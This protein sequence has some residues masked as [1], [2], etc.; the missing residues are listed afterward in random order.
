MKGK[1]KGKR[2]SFKHVS[3]KDKHNTPGVTGYISRTQVTKRLQLNI[4]QFRQLCILKGVHPVEPGLKRIRRQNSKTWYYMKD[5]NFLRRDEIMDWF[6][7][8]HIYKRKM[9]HLKGVKK[10][11]EL[12][13]LKQNKPRLNMDHFVRERYPSLQDAV[14]DLDDAASLIS[15]F[16]EMQYG[17]TARLMKRKLFQEC[18]RLKSEWMAYVTATQALRKV[19]V[20]IKGIYYQAEVMG[21]VVTW[22]VPHSQ[23]IRVPMS[24][25]VVTMSFFVQFYVTMMNFVLYRLYTDQGYKYPP[26]IEN[27]ILSEGLP[28][29]AVQIEKETAPTA[30]LKNETPAQPTTAPVPLTTAEKERIAIINSKLAHIIELDEKQT[31]EEESLVAD[32]K[33]EPMDAAEKLKREEEEGEV[34][35]KEFQKVDEAAGENK[36]QYQR[37]ARLFAGM[38]FFINREIPSKGEISFMIRAFGGEEFTDL[39]FGEKDNRITHQVVDREMHGTLKTN[40]EYVQPQWIFDSINA[41][42][43]LPYHEYAHNATLPPHISP[44][45]NDTLKG[46]TPKQRDH[47]NELIENEKGGKKEKKKKSEEEEDEESSKYIGEA[48]EDDMTEL[49]SQY[50]REMDAERD[51]RSYAGY[52]E[53]ETGKTEMYEDS[54]ESGSDSEVDE[55]VKRKPKTRKEL[56]E[57]RMK[58][59][60][61]EMEEM[62]I[63]LLNRKKRRLVKSIKGRLERNKVLNDALME[64]RVAIEKKE[65]TAAKKAK[66]A[67]PPTSEGPTNKRKEEVVKAVTDKPAKKAKK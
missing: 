38:K 15:L 56:I 57:E 65:K 6:R 11:F 24:I 52:V 1:K 37:K 26:K 28:V 17:I 59:E 34:V 47:I 8:T 48:D 4:Q 33:D 31:I 40:R 14:N 42:I 39:D 29:K 45:V 67:L 18:V 53:D 9:A 60:E 5:I 51:G 25:D 35:P 46:Y 12:A 27:D 32:V 13:A 62:S 10:P 44:F 54:A 36:E 21:S 22:L 20:S 23:R 64:K 41:G 55:A 63:D 16:V 49:E 66:K 3:K 58:K 50:V 61:N 7:D 19:F 2:H 30:V 43:L